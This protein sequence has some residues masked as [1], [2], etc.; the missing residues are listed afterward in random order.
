MDITS[1][2]P[3]SSRTFGPGASLAPRR[4]ATPPPA[5]S[6]SR[7][8]RSTTGVP[9]VAER[10]P[11]LRGRTPEAE[12]NLLEIAHMYSRNMF[13]DPPTKRAFF[14]GPPVFT[15]GHQR[16]LY[17]LREECGR[18]YSYSQRL[19]V[20]LG[21]AENT[22][23]YAKGEIASLKVRL[24]E[25]KAQLAQYQLR[26]REQNEELADKTDELEE[27]EAVYHATRNKRLS[28]SVEA[29]QVVPVERVPQGSLA[30][31]QYVQLG[32]NAL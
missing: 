30:Q 17:M 16:L 14:K 10:P 3:V 19:K 8:A 21:T 20:Q 31:A 12:Q 15:D 9:A 32:E 29:A 11:L 13:A 6:R 4:E 1:P 26:I 5:L 25:A 2:T 28:R 27:L 24:S 23:H 22:V 18:L 7:S